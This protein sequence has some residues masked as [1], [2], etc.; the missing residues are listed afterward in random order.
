[1]KAYIL[2]CVVALLS[3]VHTEALQLFSVSSSPTQVVPPSGS[4]SGGTTLYIKGLGFSTNAND[5]QVFVGSYPCVIP[6]AG[7]TATS[8][9]CIT[10][11][12]G[13]KGNIYYL[14]II[15]TSNGQQQRLTN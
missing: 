14:P 1:M 13:Q 4:V 7:A 8:L 2:L 15:V 9:A 12:S 6:A 5:N 3:Q 10:S 11:D